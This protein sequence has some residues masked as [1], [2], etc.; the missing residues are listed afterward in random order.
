LSLEFRPY[1]QEKDSDSYSLAISEAFA[2]K[3]SD[4]PKWVL[5]SGPKNIRVL[6]SDGKFAAT[7]LFIP[8]GQFFGGQSVTMQGIAGVAVRPEFRGTGLAKELMRSAIKELGE[9]GSALSTLYPSTAPL[10]NS[11]G[12]ELAGLFP[13]WKFR[14]EHLPQARLS[15]AQA[16]GLQI[17]PG[18]PEDRDEIRQL[19]FNQ[20]RLQPGFLD[21]GDYLWNRIF[22]PRNKTA[23]TY[24]VRETSSGKLRGFISFSQDAVPELDHWTELN[25][26]GIEAADFT[27]WKA[28]FAF[29]RSYQSMARRVTIHVGV[30]HP[31][32]IAMPEQRSQVTVDEVWMSRILN[33]KQALQQRGY[34]SSMSAELH[35]EVQDDL[36]PANHGSWVLSVRDGEGAVEPGGRGDLK[37][38]IRALAPLYTGHLSAEIL[39]VAG[40]LQG[41]DQTLALATSIFQGPAPWL[42]DMF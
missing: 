18:T 30:H 14:F 27:A 35:F 8:M 13:K 19:Y 17:V 37:L 20:A 7:A 32:F 31:L 29:I 1:D 39:H 9:T 12:F 40:R 22:E 16:N 6:E 15:D 10:Y 2:C 33:V 3:A 28:L 11:V 36:L 38:P 21:R 41:T 5:K 4:V 23:Y 24:L 42:P 34:P 25:I 26:Y